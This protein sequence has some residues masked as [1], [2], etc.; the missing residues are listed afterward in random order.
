[1]FM[2]DDKDRS[3]ENPEMVKYF[4]KPFMKKLSKY[5]EEQKKLGYTF[6]DSSSTDNKK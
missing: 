3:E 6:K 4:Y 2:Y 5:I 1:M